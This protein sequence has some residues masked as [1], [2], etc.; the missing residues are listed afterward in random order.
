M[1]KF[2]HMRTIPDLFQ[3]FKLEQPVLH[4]LV[5]V[6]DFSRVREEI[7]GDTRVSADFYTLI[8]K[9]YNRN[10]IKYGRKLVDFTDGSL[11]CMSPQQVLEMDDDLEVVPQMMGWGV[12]F[13]PD[14]IRATALNEKM[15][16]YTFLSY[17]V[18]EA[19]H[20]SEKEKQILYDCVQK[21]DAELHENID[22]HSQDI[23]VSGI[24]MLLN[25]CS[26]FYGRQFITRKNSNNAVVAQVEKIL[27]GY[28]KG[29]NSGLPTVKYLADKV[30][31]SP[32]YLSDL[33]KK[34][35]GKNAQDHIHYY[36]I[37]EAKNSLLSTNKSVGEIA[38]GLGFEYPQYFNKLFKQ[39]TGKTP[40]EF[41][42]N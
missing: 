22:V 23:I 11:I 2:I 35:T 14:L 39:K 19:L 15:K 28:F 42:M 29:D 24:E 16:N 17:E 18:S 32:N 36:V 20:L 6:V 40:V 12:F 26:R 33:L 4:P 7:I 1:S 31:L 3:F 9:N 41:R 21:I 38:Y 8:F 10:N 27:T 25:Y 30:N 37:E 5:A 13:H 34:E